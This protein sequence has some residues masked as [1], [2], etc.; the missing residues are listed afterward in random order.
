MDA[1]EGLTLAPYTAN[2]TTIPQSTGDGSTVTGKTYHHITL[3]NI[4]ITH[5]HMSR[6]GW[7]HA[8][9]SLMKQVR[10][11]ILIKSRFTKISAHLRLPKLVFMERCNIK[12]SV[13]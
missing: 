13:R 5:S 2:L 6:V 3:H 10:G 1:P 7:V 8:T 11:V 12:E 4:P 9:D